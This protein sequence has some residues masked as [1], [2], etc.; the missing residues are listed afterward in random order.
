[1]VVCMQEYSDFVQ[2]GLSQSAHETSP[3]KEQAGMKSR[4]ASFA[5]HISYLGLRDMFQASKVTVFDP[6]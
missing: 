2:I 4:F 6:A 3:K 5:F 1:M